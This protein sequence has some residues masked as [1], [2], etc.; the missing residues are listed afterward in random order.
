LHVDGLSESGDVMKTTLL[1]VVV[2]LACTSYLFGGA[3]AT[4]S[5][6]QVPE[7]GSIILLGTA[8]A[9]IGFAAWRNRRKN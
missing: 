2:L 8:A 3:T 6:A 1:S 9:G 5:V 7:P 4:D